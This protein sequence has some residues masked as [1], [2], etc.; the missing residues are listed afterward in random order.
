MKHIDPTISI[1]MLLWVMDILW[2]SIEQLVK[3]KGVYFIHEKIMNILIKIFFG[4]KYFEKINEKNLGGNK[5]KIRGFIGL[6]G[7]LFCLY[8]VIIMLH[9]AFQ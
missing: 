7:G 8:L 3:K 1:I 4:K 2:K 5:W 6:F 9:T